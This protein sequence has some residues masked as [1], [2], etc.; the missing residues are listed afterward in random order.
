MSG[1]VDINSD[2]IVRPKCQALA[3]T[4]LHLQFSAYAYIRC[5]HWNKTAVREVGRHGSAW[6]VKIVSFLKYR[7]HEQVRE[8]KPQLGR[9][10]RRH[11]C[12][13]GT[14]P[15]MWGGRRGLKQVVV[16]AKAWD[17]ACHSAGQADD[18]RGAFATS[19]VHLILQVSCPTHRRHHL[20][21]AGGLQ[22]ETSESYRIFVL[23]CDR[24]EIVVFLFI[25]FK[26]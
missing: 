4:L 8:P 15:C 9:W 10:R 23:F 25:D 12:K 11:S 16:V 22:S 26:I 14:K 2:P 5:F 24:C 3:L 7:E 19:T 21:R 6:T 20:G 17:T 13:E 18:E 1:T